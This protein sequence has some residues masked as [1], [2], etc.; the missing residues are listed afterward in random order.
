MHAHLA[1][2]CVFHKDQ[3]L[4]VWWKKNS[5]LSKLF[6]VCWNCVLFLLYRSSHF[7]Q[8][9]NNFDNFEFFFTKLSGIDPYEKHIDWLGGHAW[10]HIFMACSKLEAM[11][12][13]VVKQACGHEIMPSV[14]S[15]FYSP[16]LRITFIKMCQWFMFIF[17][18]YLLNYTIS[19]CVVQSIP[20]IV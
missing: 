17:N 19:I 4:K 15:D 5:K 9:L 2:Q 20:N 1:N 12:I 6:N 13:Y 18:R 3:S 8:T 10:Q 14:Y 16:R 7:Q 11:P